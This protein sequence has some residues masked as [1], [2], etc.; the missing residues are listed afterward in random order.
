MYFVELANTANKGVEFCTIR[1]AITETNNQKLPCIPQF[2][3]K[4]LFVLCRPLYSG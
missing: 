1:L 3:D 2:L 4:E